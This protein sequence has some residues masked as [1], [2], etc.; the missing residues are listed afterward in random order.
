MRSTTFL[1]P[2]LGLLS[3]LSLAS[4]TIA[5]RT[6]AAPAHLDLESV[7]AAQVN[8]TEASKRATNAAAARAHIVGDRLAAENVNATETSKRNAAEPAHLAR[9]LVSADKVNST[10]VVKRALGAVSD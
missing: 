2:L 8:A 6:L 3:G 4:P 7:S 9:E 5:V 1:L 10:S